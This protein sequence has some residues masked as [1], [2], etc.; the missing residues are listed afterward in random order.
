MEALKITQTSHSNK[1]I[2]NI[3]NEFVSKRLEIIVFPFDEEHE[4]WKDYNLNS[5]N[6]AYST[7]EPEYNL[8][9]VKEP[10][11]EYGKW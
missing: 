3:P 2:I 11:A 7:D 8:A 6:K 10:N 1:L 9:M 5:L 4:E